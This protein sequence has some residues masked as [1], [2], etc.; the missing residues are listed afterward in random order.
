MCTLEQFI[1]FS[2]CLNNLWSTLYNVLCLLLLHFY[3][4]GF[5]F[6]VLKYHLEKCHF[7]YSFFFFFFRWKVQKLVLVN[8]LCCA[9]LYSSDREGTIKAFVELERD[10]DFWSWSFYE[11]ILC[12]RKS[13]IRLEDLICQQLFLRPLVLKG[14]ALAIDSK[15]IYC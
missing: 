9:F 7:I 6:Y 8:K 2:I 12:W 5:F 14:F 3:T 10:T 11:K 1:A 15:C 4:A 13:I